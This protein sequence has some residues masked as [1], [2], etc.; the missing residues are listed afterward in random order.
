[1]KTKLAILTLSLL[2]TGC[3][4]TMVN[5][6]GAAN[7][8]YGPTNASS[9]PG[10]IKFLNQGAPPVREA[11]REDAYKQMFDVCRG[12]YKIISEGPRT[13]NE[14]ADEYY[15]FSFACDQTDAPRAPATRP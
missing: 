10:L 9:R 15:Y 4:A 8:K 11:R 12:K 2:L 7:S 5:D 3:A 1:M 6:P 14:T 13:E